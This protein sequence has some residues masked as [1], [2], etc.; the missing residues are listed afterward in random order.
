MRVAAHVRAAIDVG[1]AFH[2]HRQVVA[3]AQTTLG[4]VCL[5]AI[6]AALLYV[7]KAPLSVIPALVLIS[8]L[9]AR[10]KWILAGGALV[11]AAEMLLKGARQWGDTGAT[12]MWWPVAGVAGVVILATLVMTCQQPP[13]REI[14][15]GP[16]GFEPTTK[17]L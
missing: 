5:C 15:L 11:V 12:A 4:K 3:F 17:G 13:I 8:F 14:Q 10:R 2:E 7:L 1:W 6:A 9:P 16:E